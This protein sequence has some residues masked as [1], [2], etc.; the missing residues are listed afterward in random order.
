MPPDKWMAVAGEG[1]RV[2]LHDD[3]SLGLISYPEPGYMQAEPVL[4][5]EG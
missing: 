4:F 3:R 5:P 2:I 1:G